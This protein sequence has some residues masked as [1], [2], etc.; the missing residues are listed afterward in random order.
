MN[1]IVEKLLILFKLILVY[2]IQNIIYTSFIFF[3][4][5]KQ[6]FQDL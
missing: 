4:L 1:N 6:D 5:I 2:N 3:F